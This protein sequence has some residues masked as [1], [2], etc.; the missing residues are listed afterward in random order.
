[1]LSM[2]KKLNLKAMRDSLSILVIT[3]I[4]GTIISFVVQLFTISDKDIYDFIFNNQYF[5][6]T[7]DVGGLSLNLVPSIICMPCSILS[8]LIYSLN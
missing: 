6:I 2:F 8:S 4:V 1:M 5:F 7:I 3:A